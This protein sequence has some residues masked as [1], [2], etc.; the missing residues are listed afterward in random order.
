MFDDDDHKLKIIAQ[1]LDE[2]ELII[3]LKKG[4]TEVMFLETSKRLGKGDDDDISVKYRHQTIT[5][6]TTYKYLGLLIEP[7]LN[8]HEHFQKSYRKA[9]ARLRLLERI[10]LSLTPN[11]RR[12]IYQMMILP[13][14]TYSSI[15]N[16]DLNA[17][18][19][20]LL[21]SLSIRAEYVINDGERVNT[22]Q[23]EIKKQS[24]K[25]VRKCLDG[26]MCSNFDNYFKLMNHGLNTRNNN[27]TIMLPKVKLAGAKKS[28]YFTGAKIYNELPINISKE[29][30]FNSYVKLLKGH[31]SS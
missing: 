11:A 28:F 10:R 24:C 20:R 3:N 26:A 27:A 22:I 5:R 23:N 8:F 30:N 18:N 17:A 16:L 15:V 9:S 6:V 31:F 12:M 7:T 2:N 21:N 25:F 19:V 13:L 1:Y 4:K 14:L 29:K